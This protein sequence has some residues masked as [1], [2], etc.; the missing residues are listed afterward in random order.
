ML[1]ALRQITQ[2]NAEFHILFIVRPDRL[3][4]EIAQTFI[5]SNGNDSHVFYLYITS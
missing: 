5:R 1:D 3:L 2:E 4:Q